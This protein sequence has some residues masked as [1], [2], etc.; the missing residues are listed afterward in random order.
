MTG[1]FELG[2]QQSVFIAE[3][4]LTSCMIQLFKEEHMVRFQVLTASMKMAVLWD[5]ASLHGAR[6][7]KKAI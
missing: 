4:T 2:Y 6:S 7:Q 1:Y 3:D 5:T